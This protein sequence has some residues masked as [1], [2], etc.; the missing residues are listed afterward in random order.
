MNIKVE[1]NFEAEREP[2]SPAD[3]AGFNRLFA[4]M[5][6][7]QMPGWR[8]GEQ[9]DERA[10]RPI[11]VGRTNYLF[12]EPVRGCRAAAIMYSLLGTA[13]HNGRNPYDWL[14]NTLIRLPSHP[15]SRVAE[16][17]PLAW[18]SAA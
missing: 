17:L 2:M 5:P 16:L 14:K 9:R 1:E 12:A 15:S 8:I 13:K 18:P 10:I 6:Q 11:A 4:A 7:P 3:V